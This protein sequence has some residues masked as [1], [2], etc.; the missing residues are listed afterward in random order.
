MKRIFFSL[1]FLLS[2]AL[3]AQAQ[4]INA[5][6]EETTH[7]EAWTVTFTL[8]EAADFTALSFQLSLPEQLQLADATPGAEIAATHQVVKGE[9]ED[10]VWN[11]ILYSP[12]STLFAAPTTFSITL[13]AAENL[14]N[15]QHTLSLS[16]IR[17]ANVEGVETK[18][19]NQTVELLSTEA[20]DV[21]GDVNGD[22]AFSAADVVT[23]LNALVGLPNDVY[24]Q[25]RA[26]MDA[27]GEVSLGD[28]VILCNKIM[29][30]PASV[31]PQ[32]NLP[33]AMLLVK[34]TDTTLPVDGEGMAQL[35]VEVDANAYSAL[36]MNISLPQGVELAE[37]VL[38][39]A[40]SEME[41]C[42]RQLEDGSYR[43]MLYADG[44][45]PLPT[46]PIA[47]GLQLKTGAAIEGEMHIYAAT[48]STS[49]GTEERL[50]D[51]SVPLVVKEMPTAINQLP[52]DNDKPA[53]TYD[54]SGRR[55]K[56]TAKG[57]V[58][59]NGKKYVR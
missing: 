39:A 26:D 42:T 57:I 18:L 21:L 44:S 20:P 36:Q 2:A 9:V 34:P 16:D 28:V 3:T 41:V 30:Q 5:T 10:N 55:I 32:D 6:V 31:R 27:N 47:L 11:V 19:D 15:S 54:L 46:S 29:E 35:M 37:V 40:L 14:G 59:S 53:A 22:G 49:Q 48:A 50:T 13:Q 7:G 4:Q 25:E 52:A 51:Q 33:L 45:A 58:I 38:P 24:L 8:G 23:L 12:Q 1:M 43:L 56:Q 17:L